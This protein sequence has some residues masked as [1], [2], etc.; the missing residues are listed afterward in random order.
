LQSVKLVGDKELVPYQSLFQAMISV[1]RM[2]LEGGVSAL[3]MGTKRI[4]KDSLL[5][6]NTSLLRRSENGDQRSTAARFTSL[7]TGITQLPPAL[8]MF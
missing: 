7:D 8:E 1:M 5:N 3:M 2:Y 4:K 6:L